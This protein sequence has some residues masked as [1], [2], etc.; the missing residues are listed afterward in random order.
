MVI[1]RDHAE[2]ALGVMAE[3][4][5]AGRGWINIAP[6]IVDG[7]EVPATPGVLAVFSK[8]GPAVPLGTWTAPSPG[9]RRSDPVEVGIQHGSG[10]NAV[11]RLAPTR[12]HLPDG[13]IKLQDHPRRGLAVRPALDAADATVLVWLLDALAE[14]CLPPRTGSFHVFVYRP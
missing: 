12:A 11:A 7:V 5:H 9:V 1:T 14:L 2:D 3:L 10:V 6:E 4:T 13:W 8:R